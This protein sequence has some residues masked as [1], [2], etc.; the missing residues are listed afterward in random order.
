MT[1]FD[2]TR[3]KA[4]TAVFRL[5][6]GTFEPGMHRTPNR[7]PKGK[8]WVPGK[9]GP[10]GIA[11]RPDKVAEAG[12]YFRIGY[13]VFPGIVALNQ[14]ALAFEILGDTTAAAAFDARTRK[15]AD[16]QD[17]PADAQAAEMGLQR[18]R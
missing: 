9:F 15:Q 10:H 2:P 12:E 7:E 6:T 16:T 13:A 11:C 18:N 5:A 3:H 8:G 17:N 1:D 4:A 14:V